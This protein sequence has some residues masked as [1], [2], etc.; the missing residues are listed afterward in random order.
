MLLTI[1]FIPFPT[2]LLG[3]YVLTDHA[4]PA[5]ILYSAVNGWQAIGW[6]LLTRTAL[7]PNN[8]LTKNEK[9]TL[10]MREMHK[11]S[12]FAFVV[13]TVCAILAYWFPLTIAVV[14]SLIWI[15][16]LIYGINIKGE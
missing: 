6:N 12:Y 14:I 7:N 1:V 8:L 15:V 11:N 4:A 13:Y 5:V 16:W 3:E 10:A 2:A 9:S